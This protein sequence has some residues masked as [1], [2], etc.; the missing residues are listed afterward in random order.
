VNACDKTLAS[1]PGHTTGADD[2]PVTPVSDSVTPA[3]ADP[4][5][6]SVEARLLLRLLA[7]QGAP[8]LE[9]VLWTGERVS[10]G[11]TEPV[12]R[13]SIADR[14]TLVGILVDPQVRFGD[15]YSDGRITIEGDL[16]RMLEAVYRASLGSPRQPSRL[17][18]VLDLLHRPRINS[19][20]GSRDN[21]HHHYD[22][23][24]AFYSLWLGNTMA[25]TCAYYPTPSATLDEAQMAKMHHVCRKLRLNAGESVVEA[26]CGWGTLALHMARHYGVRVRAFNISHEQIAYARERAKREGLASLVEYVEDDYRNISGRYDAFVSIGM[27]EHVGP[28]NYPTLGRVAYQSLGSRGRGLIHSIGCNL[29]RPMNPWI[30][31]RIFPGAYPPSLGEMMRI[32]EPWDL[33]VLDV[34]NLRL[35]Y[36]QTLRQ[37]LDL[38]E[39]ARG[40]VCEMFDERFVR[41]WRLYLSGSIAAF[42]TGSLQLFQVLFAPGTNNEVPL[43][44]DHLYAR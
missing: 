5:G 43:T 17:R 22:I 35:H 25:Y 39:A 12:A 38:Y 13:V 34:E 3:S 41:M 10:T 36:A 44:R 33:S 27:L 26:G 18:R 28:D 9:F 24:N 30:E 8:P 11:A 20:V 42:T 2:R 40:R 6:R 14:A 21:I 1:E 32:F 23:G 29:P 4:G 16:V 37:W 15:A 19:L 31:K 7:R